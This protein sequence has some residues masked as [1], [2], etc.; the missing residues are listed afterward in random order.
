MAKIVRGL[1]D[2]T[3][4][5]IKEALD[6]YEATHPGASADLYRQNNASIRVRV[7][8][9]RFEGMTKSR[10]HDQVWDF[11]TAHLA[12]DI[13]PDVSLLLAVAPAELGGSLINLEFEQPTHSAL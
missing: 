12:D 8:D 1:V 10:R 2:D 11:L 9:R 13:L 3:V 7:I 6:K 4:Q 5:S